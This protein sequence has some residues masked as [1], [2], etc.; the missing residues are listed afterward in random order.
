M[1]LL[2]NWACPH[3]SYCCH[4]PKEAAWLEGPDK[5]TGMSKLP[6]HGQAHGRPQV[7]K[8]TGEL[9]KQLRGGEP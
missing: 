6:S 4:G 9:G 5:G 1:F 8:S 3:Y 7:P 2:G